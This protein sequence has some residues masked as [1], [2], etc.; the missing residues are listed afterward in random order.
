MAFIVS[1]TVL[2]IILRAGLGW[3]AASV[4]LPSSPN[5]GSDPGEGR[6]LNNNKKN[7]YVF[8]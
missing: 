1:F 3:C 5:T 6:V 7:S 2:L 8:I 4:P